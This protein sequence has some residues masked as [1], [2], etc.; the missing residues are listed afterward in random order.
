[1]TDIDHRTAAS[2]VEQSLAAV[3]DPAVVRQLREDSP[4][5]NLGMTSADAVCVCDAI[6]AAG[7]E[8]GLE[9][10]L[11]D[12]DFADV[13]TVADLIRAVEVNVRAEVDE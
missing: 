4:L 3:F 5:S 6:L 13:S 12:A 7:Q 2:I 1:M 9:C 10:L 8:A 11:G